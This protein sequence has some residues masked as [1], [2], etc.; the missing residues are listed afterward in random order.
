MKS[1]SYLRIFAAIAVILCFLCGCT[2]QNESDKTEAADVISAQSENAAEYRFKSERLRNEHFEKH[3][4]EF[5]GLYQTA[6]EYEAGAGKVIVSPDALH[7]LEAEDGDDVYYIES[8]NEF[9]IVS[10]EG[11]IRT[12]FKPTAGKAYFDKQ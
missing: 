7:K 9:V 3:G 12:Y 2:M 8:T 1:K 6:E 5:D 4:E 10:T 11:Y